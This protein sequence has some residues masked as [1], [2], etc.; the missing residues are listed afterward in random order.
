[1]RGPQHKWSHTPEH[2]AWKNLRRRCNTPTSGC[3]D[4]YGGRGIKVCERWNDF[5]NFLADMGPR[6]S[7][8]HSVERIDNDGNYEPSNCR[9]ATPVEQARNKCTSALISYKGST[10]TLVEWC[11]VLQLRYG[12]IKER[13]RAGLCGDALFRPIRRRKKQLLRQSPPQ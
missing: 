6:P 8:Q 11:E 10:R 2:M 7:P 3:F 4:R 5:R 1:M 13:R 9:W 12:T